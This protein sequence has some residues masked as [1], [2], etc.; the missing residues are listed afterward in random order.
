MKT[1]NIYIY[2]DEVLRP[3]GEY[4]IGETIRE[5]LVRIQEQDTTSNAHALEEVARYEVSGFI[6]VNGEF[7]AITDK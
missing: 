6:D 4:K 3:L 1:N 5:V 7:K 2:T